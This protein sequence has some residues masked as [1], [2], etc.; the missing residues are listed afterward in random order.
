MLHHLDPRAKDAML[1]EVRRVLRPYGTLVL[2]DLGG[3]RTAHIRLRRR[4]HL[5]EEPALAGQRQ[6]TR[7]RRGPSPR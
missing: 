7:C 4:D 1:A 3:D 6:L 5:R 2:A